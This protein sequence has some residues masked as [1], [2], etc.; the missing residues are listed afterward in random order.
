MTIAHTERW[1]QFVHLVDS[2]DLQHIMDTIDEFAGV[3]IT[4]ADTEGVTRLAYSDL[5]IKA[6]NRIITLMGDAGLNVRVAPI[7]NIFGKLTS[8]CPDKPVILVGSHSDSVVNG[9]RYD[10]VMGLICAIEATRVLHNIKDELTYP[11][12]VVDFAMEESSRFGGDYGFGSH[13]MVGEVIQENR[14]LRTDKNG[15]TLAA[16][17]QNIKRLNNYPRLDDSP[18]EILAAGFDLI[19]R[20]QRSPEEI[21]VYLEMHIE[22]SVTLEEQG[23]PIGAVT[24]AATPTRWELIL[25]RA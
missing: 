10:G 22:Q 6:R 9:G 23:V 18:S 25:T 16:A 15:V 11:I 12:E 1:R 24:G 3:S 13:V 4:A 20:S 2:I 14:L 5:D 17:L 19:A 8:R 21:K 7:G